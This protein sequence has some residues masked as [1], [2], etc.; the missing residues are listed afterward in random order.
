MQFNLPNLAL[1]TLP[2]DKLLFL[3]NTP[4]LLVIFIIFSVF[5][6]I[7]SAVIL[8]HWSAY[9]MKSAGILIA[10]TLFVFVSLV[11]LGVASLALYY[12]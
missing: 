6:I 8:Y 11:L 3:L 10:E 1:Q 7:V 4:V 5:Y 12:F 9:G 2:V